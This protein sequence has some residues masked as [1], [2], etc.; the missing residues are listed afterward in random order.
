LAGRPCSK[1]TGAIIPFVV[2]N[3]IVLYSLS[4][5]I[6]AARAA[7]RVANRWRD[8]NSNSTVEWN[9]FAAALSRTDPVRPI[10]WTI[11]ADWQTRANA[12]PENSPPWSVCSTTPATCPP[13]TAIAT[14][15]AAA[16]QV[17]VLVDAEGVPDRP[18]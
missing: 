16:V 9:A 1:S 18:A 17:R 5:E 6:T 3:R 11:P 4:Q 15:T 13:R 12:P 14:C 8:R 7:W 2:C 10:D